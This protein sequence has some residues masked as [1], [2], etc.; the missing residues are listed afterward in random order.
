MLRFEQER[1]AQLETYA[2]DLSRTYGE[3]RRHLQHMTVLHEAN[4]RIASALD[5]DEVLAGVLDSLG[6][7]LAYRTASADLMDLDVVGPLE[8]P[9]AVIPATTPPRLRAGRA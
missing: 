7:M 4:L 6:Q 9:H 2:A 8:G 5:P 1:S 3:L